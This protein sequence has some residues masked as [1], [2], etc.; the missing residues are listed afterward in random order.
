MKAN[1]KQRIEAIDLNTIRMAMGSVA[2]TAFVEV[3]RKQIKTTA[4]AEGVRKATHQEFI[5]LNKEFIA[6]ND[7]IAQATG[8]A[9]NKIVDYYQLNDLIDLKESQRTFTEGESRLQAEDYGRAFLLMYL[10]AFYNVQ[11]EYIKQP[12]RQR[13]IARGYVLRFN[14]LMGI[15]IKEYGQDILKVS[16][17][18]RAN[19]FSPLNAKLTVQDIAKIKDIEV[20]NGKT[21]IQKRRFPQAAA[22][23]NY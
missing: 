2:N 13:E 11:D 12:K 8:S 6:D 1:Y 23:A 14:D 21:G 22:T 3:L 4:N 19:T 17:G 16:K 15:Y 18:M 10:L 9:F 5:R 20:N 7:T